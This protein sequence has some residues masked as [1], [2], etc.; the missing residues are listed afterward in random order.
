MQVLIIDDEANIRR[1]TSVVFESLG[2]EVTAVADGKSALQQLEKG[3]FDDAFLDLKLDDE[4][5]L[6]LLP[7]LLAQDS[8]LEVVV[9]SWP[10]DGS[11]MPFLAYKRDRTDAA[12]SAPAFA[13][14]LLKLRD[15][16]HEVRRGHATAGDGQG[17]KPLRIDLHTHILPRT[18]PDLEKRYGYGG[19][20][21]LE[22]HGPGCAR[23]M[24]GEQAFREI[25]A[26]CWDPAVRLRDCD[27]CGVNVQVLSTVP[28]MFSYWARP[29]DAFDLSRLLNDHIAGIVREHPRRFVGLGTIPLQSPELAAR[30]LER[31]VRELGMAGVQIGTHVNGDNLEIGIIL[32][33]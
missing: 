3:S 12:V 19:F 9:F 27:E 32:I 23:M 26:N 30:E 24:R 22:H 17:V 11:M 2:H 29:P 8:Q 20:I 13:R 31:C 33:K 10:S 16:V 6:E 18:W 5:G 21:H 7:K 4:D 25:G 14:A 28:V 15:F 1:T